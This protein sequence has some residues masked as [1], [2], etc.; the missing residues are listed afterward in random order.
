M[1]ETIVARSG[2][3]IAGAVL[4]LALLAGCTSVRVDS[5]QGAFEQLPPPD[6]VLVYDF[7]TSPDD[8][9]LDRIGAAVTQTFKGT[10][11]TAQE[12]QLGRAV[13]DALAKRLVSD[14]QGMGLPAER[15]YAAPPAQGRSVLVVGQIVSIDQGSEA[16]RVLIG[17]GA[18]SSDVQARVQVYERINGQTIPLETLSGSSDSGYAPGAA[19]TMGVGALTGHLLVSGVITAS[20]QV[21][22]QTLGANVEAEAGRLADKVAGKLQPLFV[23]QGWIAPGS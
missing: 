22:N 14:I 17:L 23:A 21:A 15:A 11:R 19:E 20:S 13:A 3:A 9:T 8:V 6:R 10:P 18:G 5:E 4:A 12:Q 2:R 16:E 7:A 1:V